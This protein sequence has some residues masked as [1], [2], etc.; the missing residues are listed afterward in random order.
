MMNQYRLRIKKLRDKMKCENISYVIIPTGDYHTSEYVG[1]YFKVREFFSGFTGSNGTLLISMTEA[2]LWTDGRYFIQAEQELEGS[3]IHLMRMLE[4]GVPSLTEYLA[5]IWQEGEKIGFDGKVISVSSYEKINRA[6]KEGYKEDIFVMTFDP[7][8]DIWEE[9]PVLPVS[10]P[11]VVPGELNGKDVIEKVRE[12]KADLKEQ[13]ADAIWLSK[14]DDIMWLFNIRANDIE[15]NPVALSYAYLDDKQVIL[16]LQ[17]S[18]VTEELLAYAKKEQ[19]EIHHYELAE[20]ETA[21]IENKRILIDAGY[22]S[23]RF[24]NIL[25][26]KNILVQNEN[27]TTYRKAIKNKVELAAIHDVYIKDSVTVT[28]FIYWLKH[29]NLIEEVNEMDAGQYLDT[30]RSDIPGFIEL[31]FPTISAYGPNAAMMHYEATKLK[32]SMLKKEGFLLVDSGGQYLG[33]TTDITRTISLG[34]LSKDMI[35]HYTLVLKGNLHLANAKFLY[36]C[37]GRNLDILAREPLWQEGIDYKCGTGHGIGYMLNVHEG[38]QNIRWHYNKEQRE[39]I[40]EEGML[41]TDEPGIYLEGKYGI[42]IENVLEC[43]KGM[44]TGD[45]QFMEFATLN[46]VPFDRAAIDADILSK[47]ELEVLNRYHETVYNIM[48]P[49]LTTEECDWLREETAPII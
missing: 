24:A 4:E 34:P 39:T 29:Q 27:P 44:K 25:T 15:C 28:K 47:E 21:Q 20:L 14:L 46:Y 38:P 5:G 36:G 18:A 11:F 37:T 16:Y 41:V 32:K 40:L 45:G 30:M 42:R 9:R 2:R 35:R 49:Y 7:A 3:D 6:R 10:K 48:L 19:F 22:V 13:N 33:G 12:L 8:T 31:S 23:I 26:S 43:K 17:K 1:D